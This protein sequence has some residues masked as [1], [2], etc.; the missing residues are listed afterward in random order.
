MN[1]VLLA[2]L[3]ASFAGLSTGI[4]SLI[5]VFSKDPGPRFMSFTLG[6]SA[7]VM[8]YVSLSEILSK[9][10]RA[11]SEGMSPPGGSIICSVSFFAGIL[12][13]ALIGKFIPS[14]EGD[15]ISNKFIK[16]ERSSRFS[17][18]RT[19]LF[20]AFAIALHN[21]PEGMATF[22][23]ALRD[24]AVALPVV[25]AIAIHNVPEGIAVAAPV[26]KATGSTKTAF[27]VSFL[28]GLAEPVGALLC[29]AFL[30]PVMSDTLYGIV[31]AA[32][33]GIMVYICIDE[34]LPCA[35]K[36]GHHSLCVLGF[37]LGMA[38]MCASL[39]LF[40]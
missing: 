1:N 10:S 26:Y 16:K 8:I 22:V 31:F 3:M 32:A 5:T 6:F 13:I 17:L 30:M 11:L 38:I 7:G 20:S 4:G 37:V 19:G 35:E 27:T 24:P 2:F 21:F 33:A 9:A 25:I 14:F 40:M 12:L 29:W 28:S 36:E 34:I 18:L 39:I 15:N 23:S